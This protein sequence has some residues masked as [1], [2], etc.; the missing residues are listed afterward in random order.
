MIFHI[1]TIHLEVAG[2]ALI[3]ALGAAAL[4]LAVRAWRQR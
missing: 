3:L 4:W 2:M 1:D